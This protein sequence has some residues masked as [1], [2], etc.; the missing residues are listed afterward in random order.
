MAMVQEPV[1]APYR[2]S[3]ASCVAAALAAGFL[4][5][6]AEAVTSGGGL[7]VLVRAGALYAWPT[8]VVG[9]GLGLVVGAWRTTLGERAL[10]RAW[11]RLSEDAAL[12][13]RASAWLLGGAAAA[14]G[15]AGLIAIASLPLVG[16][17]NRKGAGAAL[18]AA[19]ALV[20]LPLFALAALPLYRVARR[21]ATVLPRPGGIPATALLVAAAAAGALAVAAL[22]VF[23]RLDWRALNAGPPIALLLFLGALAAW[24]L[25]WSGPL[26]AVRER[27]P[28]REWLLGA[29]FAGSAVLPVVALRGAPQPDT[30]VR[31]T[32]E[33]LAAGALM[34]AGRALIDGDGDGYSAF[35]GGP[36]CD[37]GNAAVHPGAEE[38][39]DNGID[40]NCLGGDGTVAP[41]DAPVAV[42][43]AAGR[44]LDFQGNLLVIA[45]DTLRSDKM[46]YA[47]Y[48]RDGRSLTPNLDAFAAGSTVFTAAYAQAPNTPRSLPSLFTSQYP[49]QV[50][51]EPGFKNYPSLLSDN[52][53]FWELLR[54]AGLRTEGISSHHYFVPE[55]GITQGFAVYDNAGALDI[56]GSNTDIAAP[57]IVPKVEKRLA[58]LGESGE[59]FAL[60][61]HL[62][63]PHSRY[64]THE[65]YPVKLKGTEGLEEKYDW[66]IAYTDE[67]IGR[68]LK[69]L[70]DHGLADD[71]IVVIVSDHGE[72]F[73]THKIA[74]KKMFFHGQTL[75][76][77][78][79]RVP[80]I[81]RVP[82]TEPRT[83]T[84]PVMLIDVGPTVADAFG[85]PIP[86]SFRGRSLVPAIAG[87]PLD[88]RPV[89][90]ELLPAPSWKHEWRMMVSGDGAW[91]L[92]YRVSDGQWEL[93]DLRADPQ[94]LTNLFDRE[95][96]RAAALQQTMAQWIERRL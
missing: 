31:L 64:M 16:A 93:Y 36:D 71:T 78:L 87:D 59:R 4:L 45:V 35:L 74:G 80:L 51:F 17:V 47:G 43:T 83:V 22:V 92:I 70:D 90:G 42:S 53:S 27:V 84:A 96:E 81:V 48:R 72:A 29:A 7:D 34:G 46:G 86:D 50:L 56:A 61:T 23:T 91:K 6:V 69:A 24:R 5:A 14:I 41:P 49:S 76:D 15:Y 73:G 79:L 62:F 40:D 9:V 20:G 12:D 54:D 89:F 82:G 85:V 3:L 39:P 32:D 77:E 66:E 18:L 58:A 28:A 75:Y 30:L 2:R 95:P 52:V 1:G 19:V 63:E 11:A 8:L 65:A 44:K 37:D 13:R 68:I 33:T 26:R 67:W 94:E 57:R 10:S 21:V 25:A 55:R 60:F 88:E 38:I